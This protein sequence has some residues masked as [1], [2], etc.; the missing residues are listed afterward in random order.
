LQAQKGELLLGS[1]DVVEV[2]N[3][4]HITQMLKSEDKKIKN[5]KHRIS[6][7]DVL[8]KNAEEIFDDIINNKGIGYPPIH[9]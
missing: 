8:T 7:T 3:K 2:L 9:Y 5:A 1:K 4:M 6:A